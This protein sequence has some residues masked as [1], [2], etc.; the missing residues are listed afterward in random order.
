M[1]A[2]SDVT[3]IV[4]AG[5]RASRFGSQKLA[6]EIGGVTVL[7]R[8]IRSVDTVAGQIILAGV[9]P[10]GAAGLRSET[11]ASFRTLPDATP[12]AGPLVALGGALAT[13]STRYALV[14][15]GDMPGLVPAV[16]ALMLD[17]LGTNDTADAVILGAPKAA[18]RRQVLPLALRASPA[19]LAIEASIAAGESSLQAFLDRLTWLADPAEAWLELDPAGLTVL[20]I[21]RPIDLERARKHNFR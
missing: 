18:D 11:E 4:L 3:A 12:F 16:L 2:R 14:A 5:G 21:D 19:R 1:T 9:E 13:T 10:A 8:A 15:G 17:L 6:A 7:D 20:D